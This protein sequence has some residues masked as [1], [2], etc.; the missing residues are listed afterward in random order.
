MGK[1][2]LKESQCSAKSWELLFWTWLS[3]SQKLE[4]C[5]F[6]KVFQTESNW[7]LDYFSHSSLIL[8]SL[9]SL[10][11]LLSSAREDL[12]SVLKLWISTLHRRCLW[13]ESKT[14]ERDFL[15]KPEAVASK[16]S[17]GETWVLG[18]PKRGEGAG[19][20]KVLRRETFGSEDPLVRRPKVLKNL[21]SDMGFYRRKYR[22]AF[23]QDP[24]CKYEVWWP[25]KLR[26]LRR[27]LAW[28][29]L[30]W[31]LGRLRRFLL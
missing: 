29:E 5:L 26:P 24:L 30:L 12:E 31:K 28:A 8:W 2:F 7:V 19:A 13:R 20:P 25:F 9:W 18:S 11:V 6:A 1:G 16:F 4:L 15:Y 23:R 27:N 14:S 3:E 22:L 21:G 17:R 10:G